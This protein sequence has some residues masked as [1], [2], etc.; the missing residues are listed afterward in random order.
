M[1]L[2]PPTVP[3]EIGV[4]DVAVTGR[5]YD[6]FWVAVCAGAR[7]IVN[8][9]DWSVPDDMEVPGEFCGDVSI[10]N[11]TVVNPTTDDEWFRAILRVPIDAQAIEDGGVVI[12]AGDL[13]SPLR[14]NVLLRVGPDDEL[15]AWEWLYQHQY[16]TTVLE[17]IITD[18][19]AFEAGFNTTYQEHENCDQAYAAAEEAM[20]E[21]WDIEW[22]SETQEKP[23]H[24][25]D[26][27]IARYLA[28]QRWLQVNGCPGAGDFSFS[29]E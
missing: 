29:V 4:V 11:G 18:W 14:G 23:G 26:R 21:S 6:S 25:Y 12:T 27:L 22:D 1:T 17:S 8:P 28:S 16:S 15:S 24:E 7:G 2:D 9:D 5:S 10:D 13:W 19:G 3:A 20:R